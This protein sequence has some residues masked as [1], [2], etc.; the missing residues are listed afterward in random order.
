MVEIYKDSDLQKDFEN[1]EV[2]MNEIHILMCVKDS[3]LL[4]FK[5]LY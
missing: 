2:L 3:N 4:P 5:A 1:Y